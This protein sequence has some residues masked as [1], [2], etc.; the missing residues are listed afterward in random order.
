MLNLVQKGS[1]RDRRILDALEEWGVMDTQLIRLTHFA[2]KYTGLRMCQ[3][4]M[5]RLTEKKKVQRKK[6]DDGYIYYI[7]DHGRMEHKLLLNWV[8]AW[9]QTQAKNWEEVHCF[10]YEPDYTL[11]RADGFIA[12]KNTITGKFRFMHIEM[13]RTSSNKFD[14]VK[15]YNALFD[16]VN[17]G[18][19]ERWW[20]PL[21]EKWPVTLIVTTSDKRRENILRLIQE[22]NT[23]NLRF[24]VRLLGDI[25][26]EVVRCF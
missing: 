11:L 2:D 4:R 15:K 16:Q 21:T 3:H 24:D 6:G 20:I 25:R 22:D 5:K 1:V 8:R 12:I 10:T 19:I 9:L 18:K 7:D 17:S 14:K 13:D 26:R 23:H